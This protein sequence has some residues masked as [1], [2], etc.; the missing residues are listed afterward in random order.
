M[1]E[2]LRQKLIEVARDAEVITYNEI[3]EIAGVGQFDIPASRKQIGDVLEE[4]CEYEHENGRPMLSAVVVSKGTGFP[5]G[6]FF[7]L[8][9][10]LGL[11]GRMETQVTFF[12][13]ELKKVHDYWCGYEDTVG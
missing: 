10:R 1:N 12:S 11:M 2:E 7:D 3:R 5:G 4:I 9:K 6:G 8:A 13:K